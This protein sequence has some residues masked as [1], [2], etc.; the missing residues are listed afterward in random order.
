MDKEL[1]EIISHYG[2]RDQLK[3]LQSE[4]YELTEA[5]IDY[6][7]VEVY[8]GSPAQRVQKKHVAEEIAD[9]LVML[10]QFKEYYH[11]DDKDIK[12]IMKEKIKRQLERIENESN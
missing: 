9:V 8:S 5:I 4:V 7:Y 2:V 3:Y 1:I 12:K 6:Q 10:L 11:I